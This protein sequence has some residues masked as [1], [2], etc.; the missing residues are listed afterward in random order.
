MS[1]KLLKILAICIF[2]TL[3]PVAV[4]A[5][6]LAATL[7][8]P[9]TIN[10]EIKGIKSDLNETYPASVSI[11]V[12]DT[13][14][15]GSSANA[16]EDDSLT[17]AFVGDAYEVIGFYQG[18]AD[19]ITENSTPL[20]TGISSYTFK[21]TTN[22]TITVWVEAKTFTVD[23][24]D[25]TALDATLTYG[26][27][28]VT[29]AGEDFAGW[30]ITSAPEGVT[31]DN[32]IY[33]TATFAK[34]G[35]YTLAPA[36]K[37]SMTVQYYNGDSL[38]AED[39]V[40]QGEE[41]NLLTEANSQVADVIGLGYEFTGWTTAQDNNT[42]VTAL[43]EFVDGSTVQLYL[44]QSPIE[45]TANVKLHANSNE[46]STLTFDVAN[47][48]DAYA[49][50][51]ENYTFEGFDYNGTLYTAEGN[52]YVNNDS[53]LSQ[54][55]A[56]G[57][58]KNLT[59]VWSNVY[60]ERIFNVNIMAT[61]GIDGYIYADVNGDIVPVGDTKQYSIQF[62][63][64]NAY[65]LNDTIYGL[66]FEGQA[67]Y[68][69]QSATQ[70]IGPSNLSIYLS[71]QSH[72]GSFLLWNIDNLNKGLDEITFADLLEVYDAQYP[73]NNTIYIRFSVNAI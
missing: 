28:L 20:E 73:G 14:V 47:G 46:T 34:S 24:S 63:D 52:D 4:V 61:Q 32:T 3:I 56:T 65:D 49:V 17:I 43:P 35:S 1:R 66:Y 15:Q 39:I 11:S 21:V 18:N 68:K 50:E 38:I 2:A 71:N 16:R 8:V 70:E 42:L 41:Y 48:F 36:Y 53:K 29:L 40:Y 57:E 23:Y 27:Q 5:I 13:A 30:R 26:S 22:A 6:A 54:V 33:T 55:L 59:A 62:N 69:D 45:Y 67:L 64:T 25:E 12:N 19:S 44:K 9:Y 37:Q 60:Q 72:Q 31:E 7:S 51:R 10:V 58:N